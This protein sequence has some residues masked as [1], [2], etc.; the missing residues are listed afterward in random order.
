MKFSK[1]NNYSKYLGVHSNQVEHYAE[2]LV[3]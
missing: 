2:H 3:T 1:G